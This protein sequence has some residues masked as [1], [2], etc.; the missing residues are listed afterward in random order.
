V[1]EETL[2]EIEDILLRCDT[3]VEM[4][5]LILDRFRAEIKK[6]KVSD[7]EIAQIYLREIMRDLLL[8]ADEDHPDFF[9]SQ[10]QNRM[11]WPSWG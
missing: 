10:K 1:D 6:E 5:E 2:E 7:P 9:R 8:A 3:G 11:L 4:T